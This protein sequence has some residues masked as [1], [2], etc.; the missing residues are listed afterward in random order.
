MH[1]NILDI[2]MPDGARSS[3]TPTS[4]Q[5]R[6]FCFVF[7]PPGSPLARQLL[8]RTMTS[9]GLRRL[10]PRRHGFRVRLLAY[11]AVLFMTQPRDRLVDPPANTICGA[12]RLVLRQGVPGS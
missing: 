8:H 3:P 11:N 5:A 12:Q 7:M 9:V 6:L 4:S 1:V 10:Y 2:F